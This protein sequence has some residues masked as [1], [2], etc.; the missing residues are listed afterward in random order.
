MELETEER[1][2]AAGWVHDGTH[3]KPSTEQRRARERPVNWDS[4]GAAGCNP[5]AGGLIRGSEGEQMEL[6]IRDVLHS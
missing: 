5:A 2:R 1:A 3:G 4:M 6:H